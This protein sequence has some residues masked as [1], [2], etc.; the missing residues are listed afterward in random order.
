M[1]NCRCAKMSYT[2]YM[3]K[4][5]K[6]QSKTGTQDVPSVTPRYDV[7]KLGIDWHAKEFRVVRIIDNAGPEPAQR[8][9]P[10]D[11]LEWAQK[12]QSLASKVYSCY[13]AGA[14]GFVLH[15]QLTKLGVSNYVI[16]PRKLDPN[17]TRVQNDARDALDLAQDLD[18]YVRGNPKAL[19]RAYVP[20]PEED[21]SRQQSRQ[22]QQMQA[23]RL[24]LASQGR[25]LLL[26]QG[27][28]ES[29]RWWQAKRWEVL[30]AELPAW[31]REALER[32]RRVIQAVDQELQALTKQ[33]EAKAPAVRP[34]GLGALTYEEIEREVCSWERFTDRKGVGSYTGLVGGV[35]ASGDYHAD[36]PITKAG[37]IRLRTLLIELAWRWVYYQPKSKLIRRWAQVF[38]NPKA[39]S[40]QR[41]RAI[42]AVARCLIIDLWRWRTGRATPKELGWQ[43]LNEAAAPSPAA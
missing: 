9:T 5:Q 42:V 19:R 23:H 25:S 21:Q 3:K 28:Q 30:G 4:N 26:S 7:I 15:R 8:F 43:M 38:F 36:R 13:E 40:R 2:C 11:F 29:N 33:V 24:S 35:S 34:C 27:W 18:R 20:T 1:S 6:S 22:R 12:Q 39:H 41:K 37:N 31:M 16:A 17:N 32:L 14:G 10:K